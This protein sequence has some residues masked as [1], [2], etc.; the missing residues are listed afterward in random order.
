MDKQDTLKMMED[1]ATRTIG[2]FF[3]GGLKHP[4][5]CAK[6]TSQ[7]PKLRPWLI[8]I[9]RW[10]K[11]LAVIEGE[12]YYHRWS[13]L[14]GWRMVVPAGTLRI[15]LNYPKIAR[16]ICSVHEISQHEIPYYDLDPE[17]K[18]YHNVKTRKRSWLTRLF[19]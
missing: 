16:E 14:K 2:I 7:L 9:F 18:H 5:F 13:P 8:W 11:P 10:R 15:P 12:R 1:H 6:W 17:V 3:G 4:D 19:G